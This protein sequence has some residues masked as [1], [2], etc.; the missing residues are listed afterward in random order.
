[1]KGLRA[2]LQHAIKAG[3]AL[4]EAKGQ[5]EHGEWIPW[6]EKNC[7]F[8]RD[9]ANRYMRLAQVSPLLVSNVGGLRHLPPEEVFRLLAGQ[10]AEGEKAEPKPPTLLELANKLRDTVYRFLDAWP[11]GM[12]AAL[13]EQLR[14]LADE[15]E[16]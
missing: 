15:L 3:E 11:D 14:A 1:M 7:T 16:A 9:T 13:P 12:Q 6:V 5:V 2:G 8:C 4:V 10:G